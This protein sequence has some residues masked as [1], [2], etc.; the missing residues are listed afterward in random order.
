MKEANMYI[1]PYKVVKI[2]RKSMRRKVL[3]RGLSIEDAK[4]MVK[5]Y[6][7]N[8]RHMVVFV[9]QFWSDKFFVNKNQFLN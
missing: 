8:S 7:S 9:K 6:P 4:A 1:G 2:F 5:R 3:K